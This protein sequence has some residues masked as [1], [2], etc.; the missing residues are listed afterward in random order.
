MQQLVDL[1][2]K[3]DHLLQENRSL[4]EAKF[5]AEKGLEDALHNAE[6]NHNTLSEG[7]QTRDVQLREKDNEI[8]HLRQV[9]ESVQAEVTRLG[10]AH[11]GLSVENTQLRGIHDSHGTLQEQH[12]NATRELE[13]LRGQ[14]AEL[15]TGIEDVVRRQINSALEEKNIE[16]ERL[17][18]ELDRAKEEVRTLKAQ[19]LRS[20]PSDSFLVVR[21]EDYFDTACQHLCQHIQQ[22]VLRFSKFSDRVPCLLLDDIEDEKIRDRVELSVL[23]DSEVDDFLSDRVKRRDIFMSVVMTMVWEY[24]FTRYLFGMDRE[25]RQKLKQLE[26]TLS[27]VG[28]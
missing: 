27:E 3:H 22:W 9:L 19:I 23:D 13:D 12:E 10:Q 2:S 18:A 25:Q 5:H 17:R 15:S 16:L 6:R 7:I 1:E 14:H 28:K 8:G 20:K 21:D 4:A 24:V 26:K 11:E